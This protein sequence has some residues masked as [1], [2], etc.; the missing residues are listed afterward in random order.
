MNQSRI[1]II[2]LGECDVRRCTAIKLRRFNLVNFIGKKDR[3]AQGGIFLDPFAEKALSK[4]D[5]E[6]IE[7]RG[8]VALD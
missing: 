5:R 8:L 2:H 4:E 1:Y 7:K 6:T 3:R